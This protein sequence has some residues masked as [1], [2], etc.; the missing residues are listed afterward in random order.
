[1]CQVEAGF[2]FGKGAAD[3]D[4]FDL[5][6]VQ[7]RDA[8][9]RALDGECAQILGTGGAQS[10]LVACSADRGADG[11]YNHYFTHISISPRSNLVAQRAARFE[12][13]LDPLLGLRFAAEALEGLALQVEQILLA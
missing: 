7:L 2:G 8:R 12:H 11:A 9:K 1:A 3:D 4:V 5:F 13:G 10:S 6:D